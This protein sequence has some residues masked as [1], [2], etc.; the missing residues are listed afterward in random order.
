MELIQLERRLVG[1]P[2]YRGMQTLHEVYWQ[3]AN[4]TYAAQEE[5]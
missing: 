5:G 3:S 1:I 2:L 4:E